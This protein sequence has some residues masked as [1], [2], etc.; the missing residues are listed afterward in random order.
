MTRAG[1]DFGLGGEDSSGRPLGG[2]PGRL[3]RHFARSDFAL[4][5]LQALGAELKRTA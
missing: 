3:G 5:S 2:L 1:F 4:V